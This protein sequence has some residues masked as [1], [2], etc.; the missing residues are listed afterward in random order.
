LSQPRAIIRQEKWSLVP[1]REPDAEA[2]TYRME[3]AVC[4]ERSDMSESWQAPRCGR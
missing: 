1:D 4:Q 3:C 2:L